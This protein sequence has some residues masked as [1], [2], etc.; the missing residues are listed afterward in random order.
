VRQ[1]G[2][3]VIEI[4]GRPVSLRGV[5]QCRVCSSPVRERVERALAEGKRP[6]EIVRAL[7]EGARLSVRNVTEH[8]RRGHL[9]PDHDAVREVTE[10]AGR[11]LRNTHALG[12]TTKATSRVLAQEVIQRVFEAMVSGEIEPTIKDGIAF[13]RILEAHDRA[14]RRFDRKTFQKAF[15]AVLVHVNRSVDAATWSTITEAVMSDPATLALHM[16]GPTKWPRGRDS[17]T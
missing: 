8:R 17:I 10:I 1:P 16:V 14:E 7:P 3:A 12:V 15:R 5:P 13:A 9:P 11:A 4:D 2:L 6:T